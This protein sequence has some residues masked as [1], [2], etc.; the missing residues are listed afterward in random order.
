MDIITIH[1]LIGYIAI[2]IALRLGY[3]WGYWRKEKEIE[4]NKIISSLEDVNESFE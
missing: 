2:L 3:V 4:A 1:E